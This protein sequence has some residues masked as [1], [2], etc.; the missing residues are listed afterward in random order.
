MSSPSARPE[1]LAFLADIKEHPH[2]DGLRLIFADWLEEHGDALDQA[3]AE[4]IRCQIEH[5]RL[6][7]EAPERAEHGRRARELQQKHGKAWLGP[8]E[9]WLSNW[10]CQRG[11]LSVALDAEKLRSHALAGLAAT[12]TWAWVDEVY[13]TP[14]GDNDVARLGQGPLLSAIVSLGFRGGNVGPAGTQ[15]LGRL[16]L[17]A[18]LHRLDLDLNRI[19]DRGLRALLAS[20]HLRQL[21]TLELAVTDLRAEGAGLLARTPS[22][23]RLERLGLWGNRLDNDGAANLAR[24]DCLTH[25]RQLNLRS[26]AIGDAGAAAIASAASAGAPLFTSLRELNLADNQ[27]GPAGARALANSLP[28][29]RLSSLVLWG[30]PVGPEGALALRK[31][32]GPRVHVASGE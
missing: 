9:G 2:E 14:A 25:L 29:D 18:R 31:R 27:I 26:N 21:R 32:F 23:A 4:L 20:P 16:P 15:A 1:V 24:T 7:S 3:R 28:E 8:L 30:N 17:V 13:L 19:S 11:L 6:P 12:E 22:L 5:D 10:S